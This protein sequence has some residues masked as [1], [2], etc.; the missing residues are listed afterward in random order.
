MISDKIKNQRHKQN[1]QEE[2]FNENEEYEINNFEVV[3]DRITKGQ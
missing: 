3:E 2:M 1:D